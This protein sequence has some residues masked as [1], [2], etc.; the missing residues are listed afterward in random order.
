MQGSHIRPSPERLDAQL[1]ALQLS[2][3]SI[4]KPIVDQNKELT[5]LNVALQRDMRDL[6]EQH[7]EMSNQLREMQ[8]LNRLYWVSNKFHF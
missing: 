5:K 1:R 3:S 7:Q 4:L 2:H 8:E 6:R